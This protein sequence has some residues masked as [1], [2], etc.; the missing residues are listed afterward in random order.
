MTEDDITQLLFDWAKAALPG[1]TVTRQQKGAQ[2]AAPIPEDPFC[3][4][5]LL[6]GRRLGEDDQK[7]RDD[8]VMYFTG[9]RQ[10]VAQFRF[11][12]D[13]A[14]DLVET[15]RQATERPSLC[16]I[17]TSGGLAFVREA[18]TIDGSEAGAFMD[19]RAQIDLTFAY[20]EEY[21]DQPGWI[22]TFSFDGT[23]KG[24]AT[25]DLTTT[26]DGDLT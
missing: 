4:I 6:A 24:G 20:V 11:W 17:L 25:G 3:S 15:L 21:T 23:L 19:R 26:Y 12:A 18:G 7:M 8:G 14:R 10:V 5:R 16:E 1:V 22:E 9:E 2:E 13:T